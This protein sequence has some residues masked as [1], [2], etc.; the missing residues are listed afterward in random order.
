MKNSF[1]YRQYRGFW[2]YELDRYKAT[3]QNRLIQIFPKVEE[4]VGVS[5]TATCEEEMWNLVCEKVN[6]LENVKYDEQN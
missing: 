3:I 5:F 4:E 6:E 2:E 1:I